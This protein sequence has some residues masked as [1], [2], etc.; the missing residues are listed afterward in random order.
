MLPWFLTAASALLPGQVAAILQRS[1]VDEVAAFAAAEQTLA[2]GG[3]AGNLDPTPSHPS[4]PPGLLLPSNAATSPYL[5]SPYSASPGG[6]APTASAVFAND[7]EQAG[8]ERE[9]GAG[10]AGGAGARLPCVLHALVQEPPRPAGCLDAYPQGLPCSLTMTIGHVFERTSAQATHGYA[11]RRRASTVYGSLTL[12][13]GG[14]CRDAVAGCHWQLALEQPGQRGR[15]RLD[16][17]RPRG[18]GRRQPQPV[19]RAG[20]RCSF[21]QS[22][23]HQQ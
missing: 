4:A 18:V 2:A 16:P 11:A 14:C 23:A 22:S 5:Q 10:R 21:L 9:L 6:L 13:L 1:D 3:G 19:R 12:C 20:A 7:A 17:R 15:Q 8:R